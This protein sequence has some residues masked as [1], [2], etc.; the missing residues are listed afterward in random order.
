LNQKFTTVITPNTQPNCAANVASDAFTVIIPT[1]PRVGVVLA[2][3]EHAKLPEHAN[4][5][6]N[7]PIVIPSRIIAV[8]N[9]SPILSPRTIPHASFSPF[10]TKSAVLALAHI[11]V[12]ALAGSCV[13]A[14]V[15]ATATRDQCGKSPPRMCTHVKYAYACARASRWRSVSRR[16]RRES[17]ADVGEIE[18]KSTRARRTATKIA[19]VDH[20][21]APMIR[22]VLS[23]ATSRVNHLESMAHA[24][25]RVRR[26]QRRRRVRASGDEDAILA[27][28]DGRRVNE[29]LK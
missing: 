7:A 19:S 6:P 22:Q 2:A 3:S 15:N 10:G 25:R 13:A 14:Y 5:P 20:A 21:H 29:K 24:R 28:D 12:A 4:A 8:A 23:S 11:A 9:R 16:L 1:K 18:I 26:S 17:N 27:G